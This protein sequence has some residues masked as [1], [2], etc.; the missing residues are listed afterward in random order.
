M[1]KRTC[2]LVGAMA[3]LQ[4]ATT[5]AGAATPAAA[6]SKTSTVSITTRCISLRDL[7]AK[8]STHNLELS[9]APPIAHQKLQMRLIHQPVGTILKD[10]AELLDGAWIK[11]AAPHS[12][13]IYMRKTAVRQEDTWWQLFWSTFKAEEAE[14]QAR[15]LN[16]LNSTSPDTT[17]Y[18][19]SG[20]AGDSARIRSGLWLMKHGPTLYR[21]LPPAVKLELVNAGVSPDDLA[22]LPTGIAHETT[23]DAAPLSQFPPIFLK[24]LVQSEAFITD[25]P[26][27]SAQ[28][29][30][31]TILAVGVE[32]GMPSL[33]AY[34]AVDDIPGIALAL[35][36]PSPNYV[37]SPPLPLSGR[38]LNDRIRARQEQ[39]RA[40][41]ETWLKLHKLDKSTVWPMHALREA[42]LNS[43]IA[44]MA[45]GNSVVPGS[46]GG[47]QY[48]NAAPNLPPPPFATPPTEA[49]GHTFS[50]MQFTNP[51]STAVGTNGINNAPKI[52]HTPTPLSR[53]DAL[54]YLGSKSGMQ[55]LADYYSTPCTPLTKEQLSTPLHGS[56]PQNLDVL[57]HATGG[58]WKQANG[59]IVLFR[60]NHWYRDD[61]LEVPN[62]L[63]HEWLLAFEQLQEGTHKL[64]KAESLKAQWN[65]RYRLETGLT[66]LQLVNGLTWW[67]T[68]YNKVTYQPFA[69][70]GHQI[71]NRAQQLGFWHSLS[72]QQRL[73][74]AHQNLSVVNLTT[75]QRQISLHFCP[76]LEC[77]NAPENAPR[78]GIVDQGSFS[79][80]ST[81]PY[82]QLP[83]DNINVIKP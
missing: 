20:P 39:G 48:T 47:L 15:H 9:C 29:P 72:D 49:H 44:Q 16:V 64:P 10:L 54:T 28:L 38:M 78:L 50:S 43:T 81:A 46:N 6:L 66:S 8:L 13:Y 59:G 57:S 24:A 5:A 2:I 80:E 33:H 40:V 12:L 41:P 82:L 21:D 4:V 55:F 75:Q 25:R 76:Q 77:L 30:S 52:P 26:A 68:Q 27:T 42:D 51:P 7:L 79:V 56:L 60:D 62:S 18:S 17:R 14:R 1:K 74:L 35:A 61:R 69:W 19:I 45:I 11:G 53:A 58:S 22:L 32:N 36:E 37:T 63:L 70:I 3:A 34:R 31:S 65:L 71:A 67:M 83:F 23:I 73:L